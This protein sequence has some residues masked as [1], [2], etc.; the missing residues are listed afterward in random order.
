[1]NVNKKIILFC[2]VSLV[3][4]CMFLA[5]RGT[6][7][8]ENGR[9][10]PA[11]QEENLTGG[12]VF[13]PASG[14]AAQ[15][16]ENG[17]DEPGGEPDGRTGR[18]DQ[19]EKESGTDQTEYAEETPP[20][21]APE[22]EPPE[23]KKAVRGKENENKKSPETKSPGAPRSKK[24]KK[25]PSGRKPADQKV[26]DQ[27][28]AAKTGDAGTGPGTQKP[29]GSS[30]AA[31]T[32]EPAAPGAT[33]GAGENEC[34]LQVTCSAVLGHMDQLNESAKKVVPADGIILSGT[35]SFTEGDT[36]FDVLKKACSERNILV[37]YVF[38]PG[39]STYYVKGIG[40]LY[41]FDCGDESGWM[42]MVNGKRPDYGCSQYEVK[43]HDNIVFYY[44]C[45]R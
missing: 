45:E 4:V 21:T 12:A 23:G 29:G 38:T 28:K 8:D 31:V 7:P 6:K 10:A 14:A 36:V 24:G 30:A 41:E 1:M 33:P 43:K 35:Y 37:D 42:Y 13:S 15:G 5:G 27:K 40:Q 9:A 11:A 22:M 3:A 18:M 34:V 20:G 16:T 39:F 44:T 19:K 32:P 26:T 25:V 17:A 2:A